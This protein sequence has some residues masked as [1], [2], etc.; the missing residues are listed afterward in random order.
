MPARLQRLAPMLDT[1]SIGETT[2]FYTEVL[3]F[4]CQATWGHDPD[5]PTWCHLTR[6]G[7]ELM[8]A[9]PYHDHDDGQE[10]TD[11]PE[12]THPDPLVTGSLYLYP[13]DLDELWA[14]VSS[15]GSRVITEWAPADMVYGMR[16]FAIRDNNGYRLIF[17]SSTTARHE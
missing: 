9:N 13:D 15:A 16:E 4:T 8:F 12:H 10:E 7:V 2:S 1:K 17:G 14:Q 3:G 5:R 11:A 6:D